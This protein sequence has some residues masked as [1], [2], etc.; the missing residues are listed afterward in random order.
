MVF[1]VCEGVLAIKM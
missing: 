1:D